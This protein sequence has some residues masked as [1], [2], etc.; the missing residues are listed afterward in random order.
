M[1]SRISQKNTHFLHKLCNLADV[2]IARFHLGEIVLWLCMLLAGVALAI[3]PLS[4]SYISIKIPIQLLY[5]AFGV[6][7]LCFWRNMKSIKALIL[8]LSFMA[9]VVIMAYISLLYAVN[10]PETKNL[11]RWYLLE[12]SLFMMMSFLFTLSL[13]QSQQRIFFILLCC[14]IFYH[15]LV[16]IYDFY[17]NGDGKLGYRAMLPHYH[18]P[19]TGYSFYLLFAFSFAY[20]GFLKTRGFAKYIFGIF[21]LLGIYA[22]VCNGG[23]FAALALIVMICAPLAFFVYKRKKIAL[24]G[25]FI[26]LCFGAFVLYH[27]SSSWQDRFNFY[28][29]VNNFS[30]VWHTP[31]AEMGQY[32]N[33]ACQNDPWLICSPHSLNKHSQIYME[34]SSLARVSTLKSTL[35]AIVDNP[36]RPNG[37]HFQQFPFNIQQIFPLESINHPFS[38]APYKDTFIS[39]NTHNHNYPSSVWFELGLVGFI[40]FS[41]FVGYFFYALY[42]AKIDFRSNVNIQQLFIGSIGLALLGLVVANVFDCFP[43]RDGQ[44]FLF[45]LCGVFL[46]HFRI[47]KD[48]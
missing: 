35:L 23:R 31:P 5:I 48:S 34:Y 40:G 9:I 25:L 6:Y 4:Y 8:P 33:G 45:V 43:V 26:T 36:L 27:F 41:L 21:T 7:L 14:V 44:I 39:H 47:L 3:L 19:A 17:A 46:A 12:P 11:I 16:T 37:Y 1:D 42:K 15:P 18:I 32:L 24:L 10:V 30:Q 38:L 2:K 29:I 13:K 28:K 22:F 20:V